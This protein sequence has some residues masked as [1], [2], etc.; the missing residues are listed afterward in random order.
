MTYTRF[1]QGPVPGSYF[2]SGATQ[3]VLRR[4]GGVYSRTPEKAN[5]DE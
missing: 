3:Q 1:N 5:G 2:E 4:W